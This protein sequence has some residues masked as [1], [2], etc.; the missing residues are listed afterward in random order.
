MAE[1]WLRHFGNAELDVHSA[2]TRPCFVNPTA[3]QVMMESGIDISAHRSKSVDEYVSQSFDCV[4]TVCDNA[5][6]ECPYLPGAH[7]LLHI[8][9]DDPSFFEGT[10]EDRLNEFRRVRDIIRDE[11][12]GFAERILK[13]SNAG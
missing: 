8:P 12:R 7:V 6:E 10:E 4:L 11:M 9:F 5:R 13:A 3:I 1:G 2:G